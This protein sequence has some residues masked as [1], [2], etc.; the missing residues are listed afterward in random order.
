MLKDKGKCC[1]VGSELQPTWEDKG[2]KIKVNMEES[3]INKKK[4][5]KVDMV[6][7]DITSEQC[8]MA[9]Y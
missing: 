5:S 1:S 7:T 8:T 6:P 3:N 4:E 9:K 2:C